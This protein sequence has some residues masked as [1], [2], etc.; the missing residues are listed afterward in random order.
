MA[1]HYLTGLIIGEFRETLVTF[2][3]TKKC[4]S[5]AY[6]HHAARRLQEAGLA[7][8]MAGLLALNDAANSYTQIVVAGSAHHHACK[9]V[10]CL[11]EEASADLAI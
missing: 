11:G 9:I 5:T 10:V 1:L 7:Y 8:M 3:H 4:Y 2:A 6:M